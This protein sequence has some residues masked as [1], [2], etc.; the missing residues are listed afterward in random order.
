MFNK[1]VFFINSIIEFAKINNRSVPGTALN[2]TTRCDWL[3]AVVLS[4][5]AAMALV[6][7]ISKSSRIFID[8]KNL[9]SIENLLI[10]I[11]INNR[12]T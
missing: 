5:S 11:F 9:F 8:F 2:V 4:P 3:S 12:I 7:H 6:L 1:A 10:S